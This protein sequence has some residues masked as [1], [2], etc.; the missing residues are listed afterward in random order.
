MEEKIRKIVKQIV[1]EQK[2]D[3]IIGF[4]K[5]SVPLVSRPCFINVKGEKETLQN[6][7]KL[8]WNSF[9][10]A[11]LAVYLP[12]Y[13]EHIQTRGKEPV[14]KPVVAV[15]VKGCD[16]RSVVVLLKEKQAPRDKLVLIGVPCSGMVDRKK[17]LAACGEKEISQCEETPEG[18][19]N[20]L[21]EDGSTI[22]LKKSEFLQQ[23]CI[24]CRYPEPKGVDYI[25]ENNAKEKGEGSGQTYNDFKN[26]SRDERWQYFLSEMSR[27]IR[28][29]ACRQACPNCYC[30]ECFAEQ[31][32][33]KWIGVSNNISDVMMFHLIRIFHQSARCVE[34]DACHRACPMGIDLKTFTSMIVQDVE[35]LFD[36]YP[37][38]DMSRISPIS[39]FN[40][41]DKDDFITEP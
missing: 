26:K 25:V 29:N 34:C 18:N 31:T 20:L 33:L 12:P 15:I 22:V 16:M 19:L 9:C 1:S 2:A 10:S 41:D 36:Y 39:T 27:C 23:A 13:Y 40:P 35:E 8:V 21:M 32:D 37:D 7:E 30:K 5:G 14:K 24:D 28:C 17:V 4:E 11:N 38:F 3:V 6:T